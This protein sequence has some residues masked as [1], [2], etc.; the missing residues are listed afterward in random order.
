MNILARARYICR[1]LDSGGFQ[2]YG[3]TRGN[4]FQLRGSMTFDILEGRVVYGIDKAYQVNLVGLVSS[5]VCK[6][7]YNWD[8]AFTYV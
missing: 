4:I 3:D 2:W 1:V 6:D 8:V 5:K 7:L